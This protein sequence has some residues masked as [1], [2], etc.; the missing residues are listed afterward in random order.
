MQNQGLWRHSDNNRAERMYQRKYPKYPTI[1]LDNLQNQPKHLGM[2]EN[3]LLLGDRSL[4][5]S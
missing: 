1:Y 5:F 2:L 3:T 4:C